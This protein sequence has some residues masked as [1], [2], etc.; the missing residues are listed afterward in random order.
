MW[1]FGNESL[2]NLENLLYQVSYT[3]EESAFWKKNPILESKLIL[4]GIKNQIFDIIFMGEHSYIGM[5][6]RI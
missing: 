2:L 6:C 5:R 1:S 3:K 4:M